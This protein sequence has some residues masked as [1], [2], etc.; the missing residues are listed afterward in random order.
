MTTPILHKGTLSLYRVLIRVP[1]G[2]NSLIRSSFKTLASAIPTLPSRTLTRGS[3]L[4]LQSLN[5]VV[6]PETGNEALTPKEIKLPDALIFVI[7]IF[8]GAQRTIIVTQDKHHKNM[9]AESDK[10]VTQIDIQLKIKATA[11]YCLI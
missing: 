5:R 10:Q 6:I 11:H 7:P 3:N 4:S 1:Y 9:L 8:I 2:S